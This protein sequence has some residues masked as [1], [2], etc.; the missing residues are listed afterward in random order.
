VEGKIKF[1]S[2]WRKQALE[3]LPEYRQLIE[4]AENP[5]AMWTELQCRF[6]DSYEKL[7]DDLIGRFYNYAR[8]CLKSP[9]TQNVESDSQAAVLVSFFE[10]IVTHKCVR[11]DFHR[12]FNNGEFVQHELVFKYLLSPKE[13]DEFKTSFLEKRAKYLKEIPKTKSRKTKL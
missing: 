2:V 10:H 8:W 7:G 11:E 12:W 1:M 3:T 4:T 6:E 5:M 9:H 13:F